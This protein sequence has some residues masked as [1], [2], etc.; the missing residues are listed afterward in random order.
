MIGLRATLALA[1][2]GVLLSAAWLAASPIRALGPRSHT[3]LLDP[4]ST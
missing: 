3:F 4:V 2:G 1:A